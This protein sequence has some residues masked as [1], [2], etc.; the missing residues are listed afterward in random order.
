MST[1]IKPIVLGVNIDHV[2]TLRQ[3]RR[4]INPSVTRA[5]M[6]ALDGGAD[7]VTI[8]LREDRR[9]IQDFDLVDLLK[10]SININL[11]I[12]PSDE[13]VD[14]AIKNGPEYCCLVPEKREEL[15]T[16]GGLD[17]IN[18]YDQVESAVASLSNA[19]I[20]VSLFIEPIN[21]FIDA[22]KSLKATSIELHTGNYA[23]TTGELR[24]IEFTKIREA[25]DY[26]RKNQLIVNAGHGLDYTNVSP[27]A[28]LN[29]LSELNIGHSIVSRAVTVGL[30]TAVAEMKILIER[31]I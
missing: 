31:K 7:Y 20:A 23:N 12:C 21:E 5:A 18:N 13:M 10:K 24:N 28:R 16:E 9:H 1:R 6:D 26:G 14:I 17:L 22:A 25:A 11:E 8:H 19:G 29:S 27:I 2:A 30:K 15:T 3:A 4:S